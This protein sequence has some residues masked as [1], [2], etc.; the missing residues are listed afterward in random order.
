MGGAVLSV[1]FGSNLVTAYGM[2]LVILSTVMAGLRPVMSALLMAGSRDSGLSPI[3]LLWYDSLISVA[4]L[5]IMFLLSE[6]RRAVP[7]YF[8]QDP[9]LGVAIVLVGSAMA[10]L[11]NIVTFYLIKLTSALNSTILGNLKTVLLILTAAIFFDQISS[12]VNWIGYA[13][14]FGALFVYS[15]LN[16]QRKSAGNSRSGMP[17]AAP[18]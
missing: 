4:V 16:Y 5:L 8:A 18:S 10:L 17:A 2:L 6:E 15:Y 9:A 14:F 11:Y 1:P 7:E 13:V 3:P 12:V